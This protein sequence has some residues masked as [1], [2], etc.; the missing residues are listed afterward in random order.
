MCIRDSL[1][2]RSASLS[3]AATL[4]LDEPP[5]RERGAA[6]P[7]HTRD[8]IADLL[9]GDDG[10]LMFPEHVLEVLGTVDEALLHAGGL[11]GV[12]GSFRPNPEPVQ[13]LIRRVDVERSCSFPKPPELVRRDALQIG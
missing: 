11:G 13:L 9:F 8:Q 6:G 10:I 5:G 4:S 12:A 3:A 2:P 1:R 7:P